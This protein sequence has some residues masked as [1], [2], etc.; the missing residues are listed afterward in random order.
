MSRLAGAVK[1]EDA[2][3]CVVASGRMIFDQLRNRQ[4]GAG[5]VVLVHPGN[6]DAWL[7]N[8]WISEVPRIDPDIGTGLPQRQHRRPRKAKSSDASE[9]SQRPIDDFES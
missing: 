9:Q 6:V 7:R 8:G 1:P 2:I 3:S 5:E 4:V